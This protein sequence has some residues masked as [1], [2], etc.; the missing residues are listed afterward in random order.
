VLTHLRA[1]RLALTLDEA[2]DLLGA[3]GVALDEPAL[4]E[5]HRLTEGWPAALRLAALSMQG[6]PE[7]GRLVPEF[8]LHDR[9]LGE[10]LMGEIL[11]KVDD[12]LRDLLLRMSILDHMTPELVTALTGR[13]DAAQVLASLEQSNLFVIH[14]GGRRPWYRFHPLFGLLLYNELQQRQPDLIPELH[15]RAALWYGAQ[16]LPAK[17]LRHALAARDWEH[18]VEVAVSRWP[19]LMPGAGMPTLKGML[20]TPPHGA[21]DNPRL[22]LAFATERLDAGDLPATATFLNLVER[23]QHRLSGVALDRLRNAVAAC[24][25]GRAYHGAD[26]EQVLALVPVPPLATPPAATTEEEYLRALAL[27]ATGTARLFLGDLAGA[28]PLLS[29][30]L[31][32][33][34]QMDLP[35]CRIATLRQIALLNAV[36]GAPRD[37]S[38]Y[39]EELLTEVDASERVCGSDAAWAELVLAEVCYQQDRL[40]AATYHLDRALGSGSLGD[41]VPAGAVAIVRAHIDAATGE[42]YAA[43]EVLAVTRRQLSERDSLPALSSALALTEVDLRIACGQLLAARRL[44]DEAAAD[45]YLATWSALLRAKLYLAE[46]RPSAAV[47][48]LLPR[49]EGSPSS[50]GWTVEADL[51]Y[52]EALAVQGDRAASGAVLEHALAIAA[53]QGIRRPFTARARVTH[54]L[55]TIC[56]PADAAHRRLADEIVA[57]LDAPAIPHL[58]AALTGPVEPLTERELTVLRYLQSM[59]STAEI[60]SVLYLSVNT[61]K[62]HVKS[63]YRK[64][65]AGRRREAVE[66]ARQLHLL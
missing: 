17:A 19:H 57:E 18:A 39:A 35:Q 25:I 9:A 44:L 48:I 6:H 21:V 55:L 63:I 60:A 26:P 56:L 64:L 28:D 8:A 54:D 27:L 4:L 46:H 2:R 62:T 1:S 22:N 29:V 31:E 15:R 65:G 3:H 16:G 51:L 50:P 61:V 52:A 36:R 47:G 11:E 58:E 10:Y 42:P 59:M 45:E 53:E 37:A 24:R 40:S 66:Q 34:R 13:D 33:A 5:L 41:V 14:C 20:P 30:A 43:A 7:P 38:R 12:E 49:F 23:S 32:L